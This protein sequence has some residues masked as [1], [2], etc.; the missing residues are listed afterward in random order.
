MIK[1]FFVAGLT[2][3]MVAFFVLTFNPYGYGVRIFDGQKPP[4]HWVSEDVSENTLGSVS[5]DLVGENGKI[6]AK[7]YR[8]VSVTQTYKV[9]GFGFSG[10]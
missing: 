10:E 6:C 7:A 3:G 2:A 1:I 5:E 4:Y 8:F 9:F